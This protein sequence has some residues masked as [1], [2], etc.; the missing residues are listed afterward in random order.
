MT[1]AGQAGQ[2]TYARGLRSS[3]QTRPTRT[4]AQQVSSGETPA[5]STPLYFRSS[6]ALQGNVVM[7]YAPGYC[8]QGRQEGTAG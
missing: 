1:L 6:E 3:T 2:G 5:S 8:R 4:Q 7:R